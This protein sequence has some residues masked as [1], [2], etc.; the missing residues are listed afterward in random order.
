MTSLKASVKAILFTLLFAVSSI[1]QSFAGYIADSDL[2]NSAGSNEG[3]DQLWMYLFIC[4]FLV[5]SVYLG[6][7][8]KKEA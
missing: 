1:G 4:F 7:S 3:K 8:K 6:Y 5:L 2:S